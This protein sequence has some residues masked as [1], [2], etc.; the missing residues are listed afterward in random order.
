M[1][2]EMKITKIYTRTGDRGETSLVGG[3]RAAK[4]G[5]RIEAYGSID[6]L[7]SQ[8]GLL[9]AMLSDS[10]TEAL[11][12]LAA[13][14]DGVQQMLFDMSALLATDI[15]KLQQSGAEWTDGYLAGLRATDDRIRR[16]TDDMEK[17][18]DELNA[19]LPALNT[20]I[21][22]GDTMQGAQCHVCRAVC[23]RAERRVVTLLA[24][25][26]GEDIKMYSNTLA[27]INRLSDYLYVMARKINLI[28]EKEEK[29]WK[30]SCK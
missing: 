17:K 27:Y 28:C 19:L 2:V 25:L 14:I 15:G 12:P 20:F 18:I 5:V 7:S 1:V 30:N 9:S 24:T 29:K 3:Q 4:D 26:S 21:L 6:E 23:R 22:P 16:Q 10:D 11:H 13:E 8:L